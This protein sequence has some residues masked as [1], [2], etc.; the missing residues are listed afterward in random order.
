MNKPLIISVVLGLM[1]PVV[2][3]GVS[4]HRMDTIHVTTHNRVVVVTDPSKGVNPYKR[5]GVFP[6]AETPV[7]KIVLHVNFGCPD[8]MRCA[9]WD[10]RDNIFIRRIGGERGNRVDYEIGRMLTPYGGAF[11]KDWR[12]EWEVDVTDFSHILRDS[13]EIE[14]NHSGYE[15]NTDRGWLITLDF[16]IIKG[17]PV[18]E[19]FGIMRLYD[20]IYSYGDSLNSIEN[21]LRPLTFSIDDKAHFIRLRVYQTGHGMDEPSG[22]GEFCSKIRDI[23]FDNS[24]IDSKALWKE[25][26][27]NPLSPQAGTWIFDRANWCPGYLQIPDIY[28]IQ[29][30]PGSQHSLEFNMQPY[31]NPKPTANQAISAYIIQYGSPLHQN[32]IALEE[33]IVPN[34]NTLYLKQNPSCSNPMILVRNLGS[35]PVTSMKIQY[36]AEGQSGQLYSW[37]GNLNFNQTATITLPG[38]ILI[39]E[40]SGRFTACILTVN[41]KKDNYPYDNIKVSQ[42]KRAP[43]HSPN[44]YLYFRTN[45]QP[46]QNFY[47]ITNCEGKKIIERG[48]GTMKPGTT[49]LDTLKLSPGCYELTIQD[50]AGDGLEF[51]YNADGGRGICRLMDEKGNLVKHFESDFGSYIRYSFTIPH[52]TVYDKT[53]DEPSIGLFPTRTTGKTTLDYFC[54][55]SHNVLVQIV[56]DTGSEVV[57]EHLYKELKEGIFTYDLSYRKPQR[58]YL[59]VFINGDQKFNKRI[60]VG[61]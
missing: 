61:Q 20:G 3:K 44:L 58:Y 17:D 51:W 2:L 1:I 29:V 60:R 41:G 21:F 25:C 59:K 24:L 38:T 52:D 26:G 16:E 33:I 22:C 45:N 28:D 18:I 10:Y 11:A 46:E 7:R 19:P 23:L 50:T 48:L 12:F 9:D 6:L 13:V 34:S 42:F 40:K 54:N 35:K 27:D 56:T 31:T 5:W 15:S 47:T 36:G 49:Y 8:T 32:D 37:N 30:T 4:I 55:S 53:I 57:E 43:V 39:K 14:Y